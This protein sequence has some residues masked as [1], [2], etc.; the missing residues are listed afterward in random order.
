MRTR[1][2][3]PTT[4]TARKRVAELNA[5]LRLPDTRRADRARYEQEL[6]ALAPPLTEDVRRLYAQSN[7]GRDAFAYFFSL[8][9]AEQ[10]RLRSLLDG[11]EF[12]MRFIAQFMLMREGKPNAM[13]GHNA[14]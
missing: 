8:P 2:K 7:L 10:Q 12:G 6:E 3:K 13:G 5:L 11:G 14:E 1:R 9:V 4:A